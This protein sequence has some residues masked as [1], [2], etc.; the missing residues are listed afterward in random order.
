MPDQVSLFDRAFATTIAFVLPGLA[1]LVGAATVTPV[2]AAWFGAASASPSVVGFLFVLL[3]ALA[4]GM[5][6]TCMRWW[7]FERARLG[8]Y[9]LIADDAIPIDERK[10]TDCAAAYEDLRLSHYYHYLACA[11]MS[12]AIPIAVL[13]W[14]LGADPSWRHTGEVALIAVPVTVVLGAAGRNALARYRSKRLRLVGPWPD[15]HVA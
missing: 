4:L 1:V 6:V 7:I 8:P 15:A 11:N 9:R 2:V 10:R 12:V 5:I 13:I 3:A 14:V